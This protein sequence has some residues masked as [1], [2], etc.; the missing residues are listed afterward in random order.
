MKDYT[1]FFDRFREINSNFQS[2]SSIWR[3]DW[4]W[5]Y[6]QFSNLRLTIKDE[7]L[8]NYS[9][10]L[11]AINLLSQIVYTYF[12]NIQILNNSEKQAVFPEIYGILSTAHLHVCPSV[13]ST[14]IIYCKETTDEDGNANWDR[15]IECKT[16]NSNLINFENAVKWV[17]V[18]LKKL[19]PFLTSNILSETDLRE[20]QIKLVEEQKRIDDE[21]NGV[22]IGNLKRITDG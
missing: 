9:S 7:E 18:N 1:S 8:I 15:T 20:I 5:S 16:W 21:I 6:I 13:P 14:V 4:E 2:D 19:L 10:L 11:Y 17:I 12:P 3:R 22:A